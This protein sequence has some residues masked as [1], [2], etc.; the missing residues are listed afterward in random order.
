MTD[1]EKKDLNRY[2]K[3]YETIVQPLFQNEIT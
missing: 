1:S 2:E 3:E